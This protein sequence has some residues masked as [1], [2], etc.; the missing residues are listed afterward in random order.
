MTYISPSVVSFLR[1]SALMMD[2]ISQRPPNFKVRACFG[3]YVSPIFLCFA[4]S[5]G[6]R[7]QFPEKH[8]VANQHNIGE[9]RGRAAAVVGVIDR[10][11]VRFCHHDDL[12][13]EI[14]FLLIKNQ[15]FQPL[16]FAL[17]TLPASI[18]FLNRTRSLLT[19]PL[20][21]FLKQNLY[22]ESVLR[23]NNS[24]KE[25]PLRSSFKRKCQARGNIVGPRAPKTP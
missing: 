11:T 17:L 1:E 23:I 14:A 12:G 8:A 2:F 5:A 3:E 4:N 24:F 13:L 25:V 21:L 16:L 19:H 20:L 22:I 7:F 15:P 10:P 18:F 6:I 9:P